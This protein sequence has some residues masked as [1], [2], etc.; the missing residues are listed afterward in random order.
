MSDQNSGNPQD[1]ASRPRLLQVIHSIG[2]ALLGVQSHRNRERDFTRGDPK[3]FILVFVVA[4]VLFTIGMAI[5]VN[6]MLSG[7]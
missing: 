2:A 5:A 6:V 3:D 1:T 4:V 7:I